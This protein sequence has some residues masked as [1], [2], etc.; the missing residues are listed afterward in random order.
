M[1]SFRLSIF[2]AILIFA[3]KIFFLWFNSAKQKGVRG[4][5][6]VA[7]RLRSGL[8]SE[9][10]IYNDLYFPLA[11]GT[12]TQL[13][14]VIISRYG[15]FVVETKNYDGWIFANARSATWTQTIY[16][17]K[18]RFQNPIRQNY[19]HKCALGNLLGL[20]KEYIIGVVVFTGQC[21]FKTDMPNGVVYSRCA[22][23]YIKSFSVEV[24]ESKEVSIIADA[25]K[26][27]DASA[28]IAQ[29]TAHIANLRK[30]HSKY[31]I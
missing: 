12:T 27:W 11:D 22:A 8:P 18:S 20:P 1:D 29:R 13:D 3:L 9:Y 17:K 31:Y 26:E 4:E 28:S 5:R 19:Y 14:H 30:R 7:C 10:L 6:I 23:D 21:E 16:K 15:V 24:F 25:I 2:L